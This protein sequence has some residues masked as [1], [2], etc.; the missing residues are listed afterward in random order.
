MTPGQKSPDF[1][2]YIIKELHY[3]R[4]R[5]DSI[6]DKHYMLY[7]KVFSVALLVST[8]VVVLAGWLGGGQ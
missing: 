3:I 8:A 5:V 6:Y 2:N 1:N 4:N 7:A